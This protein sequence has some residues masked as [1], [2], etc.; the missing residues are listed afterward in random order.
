[1][2]GGL[3]AEERALSRPLQTPPAFHGAAALILV[4]SAINRSRR[5]GRARSRPVLI[6][7]VPRTPCRCAGRYAPSG[8]SPCAGSGRANSARPSFP[9]QAALTDFDPPA[10]FARSPQGGHRHPCPASKLRSPRGRPARA[11]LPPVPADPMPAPRSAPPWHPLK[12]AGAVPPRCTVLRASTRPRKAPSAQ[13]YKLRAAL[14]PPRFP[15]RHPA[16]YVHLG[17]LPRFLSC[18]RFVSNNISSRTPSW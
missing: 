16:F 1:M 3:E 18:S 10:R 8:G 2:V 6:R 13:P 5:K 12:T 17:V 4:L 15:A 9:A 11:R 7:G 14:R